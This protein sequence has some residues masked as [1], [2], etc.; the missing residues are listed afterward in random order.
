IFNSEVAVAGTHTLKL[1]DG[2]SDVLTAEFTS[3][4]AAPAKLTKPI[5]GRDL[6]VVIV[7][8]FGSKA[9]VYASVPN[10]KAS[11]KNAEAQPVP[12]EGREF[13]LQPGTNEL[14]ITDGTKPVTLMLEESNAPVLTI[15]AGA[16]NR[17]TIRIETNVDDTEVW[18][19]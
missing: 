9:T 2:R 15:R 17:G 10:M 7:S 8:H 4:V 11:L 14:T 6:P 12:A 18:I 19:N 16:A 13:A 5:A 3:Q 1:T